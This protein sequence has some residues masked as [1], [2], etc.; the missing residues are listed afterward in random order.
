MPFNPWALRPMPR[1]A[2]SRT[3]TDVAQGATFTLTFR[4]LNA[5]DAAAKMDRTDALVQRHI[6]DG[7]DFPPVGGE[8]VKVS[9]ALLDMAALL[10][11]MQPEDA[12]E[13]YTAEEFVAMAYGLSSETWI[14]IQRFGNEVEQGAAKNGS[15]P[16]GNTS[17]VPASVTTADT[18]S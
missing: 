3:F 6:T 1:P 13:R 8:V 5:V 17:S 12:G 10:E 18:R 2:Q 11:T 16:D 14:A 15:G 9:R 7:I 4:A